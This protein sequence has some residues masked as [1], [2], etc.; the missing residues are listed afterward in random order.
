MRTNRISVAVGLL[1]LATLGIAWTQ[2]SDIIHLRGK[3]YAG[4]SKIALTN[5]VGNL[6]TTTGAFSGAVGVTGDLTLG[7]DLIFADTATG[8]TA[9]VGSAQGN[10]VISNTAAQATTSATNGDAMTLPS[11]VAGRVQIVCNA[12]AANS[13][14]VF[15][16]SGHQ[17]NKESANTA[18]AL[19]AGEC[20]ICVGFSTTRWGCVIGSAT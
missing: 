11:P 2:N 9:D 8:I 14:D 18:I 3:I 13:V 16:A 4:T 20:M 7:D 17:I 12:A 1:L 19:V 15:P 6:V 10:G 5:A